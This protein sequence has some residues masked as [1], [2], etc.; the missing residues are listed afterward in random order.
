[1]QQARLRGVGNI[2]NGGL[3]GN[4]RIEARS[5]GSTFQSLAR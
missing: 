4:G 2:S 3:V 5:L 1:M